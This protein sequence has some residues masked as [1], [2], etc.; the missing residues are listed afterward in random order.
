MNFQYR[1]V[2]GKKV[3]GKAFE[4]IVHNFHYYLTKLIVY[5]DGQIA[6]WGLMSFAEFKQKLYDDWICLDMPDNSKLHIS[7]LGQIEVKQ[8]V[9]EK[10]KEDFIKE[11]EDTILELNNKPNRITKCINSF[12]SYLL[13]VSTSNF[14]ILKSQFEDLPSHQRVLFE[15]S[16]SKDPL[17]KLMQTKS[18]FTLEERKMM[19]RDYFEN[20]WDECD[21][22]G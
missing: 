2:N 19:L 21:F 7:N 9:P 17:L 15:I 8:L 18:S 12:K 3:R 13:D 20:E 4:V 5:A 6:C 16:D 14:E 11:I 22:Q 10:T 1:E